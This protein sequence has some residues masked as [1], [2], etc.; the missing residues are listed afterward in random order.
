MCKGISVFYNLA[1]MLR[2]LAG[3]AWAKRKSAV[4]EKEG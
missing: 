1:I 4:F 2:A 3:M